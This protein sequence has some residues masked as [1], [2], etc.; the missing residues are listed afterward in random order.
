MDDKGILWES[1]EI[2]ERSSNKIREDIRAER[3][4]VSEPTITTARG[5]AI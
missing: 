4:H 1:H 3:F 2:F 5:V